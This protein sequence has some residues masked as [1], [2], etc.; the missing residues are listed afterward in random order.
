MAEFGAKYPCFKPYDAEKGIN[1][2]KMV[3]AN[4]TVNL[5]SGELW[6]DDGLAE[7]LSEFASGSIAMETDN[8]ADADAAVIYDA[9]VQNGEVTYNRNDTPPEGVLGYYK[10]LIVKG[11]RKFRAYIYHRA[12]ASLGNDNAQTRGSSINF[13]TAQTTFT[14]Y[15]DEDTGNWRKTKEFSS[16]KAARAYVASETSIEG[17]DNAN[18]AALTIGTHTLSPSF[19]AGVTAYTAETTNANDVITAAAEDPAATIAITN[20][21]DSVTNG[22]ATTWETG[23][24][25]VTVTVTKG[26]V[27]KT[28]TVTVTK[29]GA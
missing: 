6:A 16:E 7:Q 2:G 27:T 14:V 28:Y 21:E 4:L 24:N 23:E 12:K 11:V 20:G 10:T 19:S 8:L 25:E 15:A 5:A 3:A 22:E 18:L 9:K 26:N 13:R 17:A 1:F 29:S